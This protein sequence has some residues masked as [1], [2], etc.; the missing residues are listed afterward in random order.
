MF[1]SSG[2]RGVANRE[3]TPQLGLAFGNAIGSIYPEVMIAHDPR[4]AGEMIENA[5]VS[6]LLSAGSKVIKAGMVP[7]PTLA[8]ASKK[9]GCGIM[10]TAS[11]NPAKY[12][13]MKV[14]KDGMSFDSAQQK[15]IEQIMK[16]GNFKY[17]DW[18]KTGHLRETGKAINEHKE[19]ILKKT[20]RSSLK[21]VVDCG[22][23]AASVI[24]PY[25]LREMGCEVLTL[26]AQPDGFFPGREPEP[27]EETLSLLK[28][29]CIASGA[30]LGIAHDG[31]ADR[32]MAVDNKGRFVSGD[33]MLAFFA[34]REARNAIAVPVDT[35]RVIDDML[36]GIKIS[37]T[38][39]GDVYVAEA[40]KKI[41]G[42]F[43]GEPSG[44]WIFP[45]IS[46]CPDGIY[47]AARLVEILEKEGEFSGLLEAIPEYPVK[48]GAF[49]CRDKNKAM[50]KITE[51]IKGLGNINTLDGVRVDLKDGWILVR[52][53][54]TEPKIRIT[55]ESKERCDDLFNTAENI[56]RG[57]I[58]S[59]THT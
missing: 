18:E 49:P 27:L 8:L 43:G 21:V 23:G 2:I 50:V 29:A 53:S 40:L 17:A 57:A 7:T 32:M 48:R 15:E 24:T 25:V 9:Y 42:D 4:I 37:H 19:I 1:G 11:H 34:I 14:F 46:F 39:V 3:I 6:G 5:V 59:I 51:K 55:V 52:P 22:C 20:G 54:G 13:G 31:D 58:E 47:A 12:I 38:K 41:N 56:V 33:K 26:N 30:D 36:V 45:E 10:I 28:S 16:E 44:A 35:S